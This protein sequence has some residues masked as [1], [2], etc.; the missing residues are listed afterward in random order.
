MRAILFGV[1]LLLSSLSVSSQELDYMDG[2]RLLRQCATG[3]SD[4][5]GHLSAEQWSDFAF[6][7]GYIAGTMDANNVFDSL[8]S[9]LC[10]TDTFGQYLC[11]TVQWTC[12]P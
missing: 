7:N 4:Y 3:V 10:G 6:C 11:T 5:G 1:F 12:V 2:N 8:N 9:T